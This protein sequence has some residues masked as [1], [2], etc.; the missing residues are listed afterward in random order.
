MDYLVR[1]AESIL[2]IDGSHWLFSH[3]HDRRHVVDGSLQE[4][5]AWAL[6]AIYAHLNALLEPITNEHEREF[7]LRVM[8]ALERGELQLVS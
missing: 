7:Q 2:Y 1:P 8:A 6:L 4:A 5:I 3:M